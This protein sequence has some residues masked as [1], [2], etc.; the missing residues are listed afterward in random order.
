MPRRAKTSP[1]EDLIAIAAL[2]P[3]WACVG[4][5]IL[6][7]VV[8][9]GLASRPL[10]LQSG[11]SPSTLFGPALWTGLAIAA[12]YI[13]P[14]IFLGGAIVSA[15]RRRKRSTLIASVSKTDAAQ[16]VNALSWRDFETLV[17]EAYRRRGYQVEE[18]GGDGPDGGI[19]LVLTRS[20]QNGREKVFVQCKQW[21]A[22]CVGVDVVRELYGV[23]AAQGATAGIV[24]TSGRF[25]DEATAFAG[26]RNVTLLDGPRLLRLIGP[27]PPNAGS[28]AGIDEQPPSCPVCAK[29][30]TRRVAKRGVNAGA[31]FWGCSSYPACRGTRPIR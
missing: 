5:A 8:F 24:V 4:L 17:G 27:V 23:M 9:H 2:L 31:A 7:Y 15:I 20:G 13:A 11:T 3:W 28:S 21:R 22:Y 12:Q 6:S 26:G 29:P 14:I 10:T 25:T 19:D 1:A 18:R 16:A 30:M